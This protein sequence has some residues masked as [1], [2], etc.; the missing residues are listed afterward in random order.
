MSVR[1]RLA[2]VA[3]TALLALASCGGASTGGPAGGQDAARLASVS[4]GSDVV[5]GPDDVTAIN[6]IGLDLQGLA[7][8]L[9]TWWETLNDPAVTPQA[10]LADA[11]RLLGDMR[12]VVAHIEAQ[13]GPGRDRS[14]R[15]TY[16]P[17]LARWREI[18]AALEALRAGVRADDEAAQQ[19]ATAA[20]NDAVR[21]VAR[22]DARRI[23][24]VVSVYG[25]DET[26][27]FLLAQGID[28]APY[29]L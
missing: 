23:D 5:L 2:V 17:Y 22:L 1:T 13:L 21:A 10:W 24:R 15:D 27:R 12:S 4:V 8:P 16:A 14:V 3:C 6:V 25:R 26:R 18:L 7:A 28:P 9:R 19:R 11:D 29:G 20:Y